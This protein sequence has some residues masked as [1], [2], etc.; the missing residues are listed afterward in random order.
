MQESLEN[1][2]EWM[3]LLPEPIRT[4]VPIINLAIPG[5][6][7]FN[8]I[9]TFLAQNQKRK[10]QMKL[11]SCSICRKSRFNVVWH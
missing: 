1:L 7:Q 3:T 5:N 9:A 11:M 10:S 6:V 4:Q 2:A 8:F